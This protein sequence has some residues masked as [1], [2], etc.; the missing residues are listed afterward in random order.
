MITKKDSSFQKKARKFLFLGVLVVLTLTFFQKDSFAVPTFSRKYQTSCMTCHAG[1]PKLNAFGNSFKNNGYRLPDDEVFVKEPPVWLGSEAYKRVWPDAVW[2]GSIPSNVPLAFRVISQYNYDQSKSTAD[3]ESK[4]EFEFPHEIEINSLG[5]MGDNLAFNLG[6]AL[7]DESERAAVERVFLMYNDVLAG[8]FGI[9]SG[10]INI[11]G[12]YIDPMAMPFSTHNQNL[13]ASRPTIY[14]FRISTNQPRVRDSQSG[15]EV[16]GTV[17]KRF[18]YATGVLNGRAVDG[19]SEAFGDNN[20]EKD[21]YVRLEHKFGGLSF[22]GAAD[23]GTGDQL[24]SGF[25]YFDQGPSM[26]VGTTGYFGVNQ[27]DAA[28]DTDSEYHRITGFLRANRD[29]YNMDMV[30]LYQKDDN[31]AGNF[32]GTIDDDIST[33]GFYT[34]G[35]VYLYPWLALV[36]RYD[37]LNIDHVSVLGAANPTDNTSRL[38]LSVPIYARPNLRFIPEASIGLSDKDGNASDSFKIRVDFAY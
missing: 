30:Y 33:W 12:G 24:A 28:T 15:I 37:R 35:T 6:F 29:R 27:I 26:T 22:T 21:I 11:R 9:P 5:T 25:S 18:R 32:A 17:N 16:Y 34:E 8:K 20:T 4:S 38:A 31:A 36:A 14:D 7:Q 1:F 13:M 23:S 2:P 19:A 10:L 3:G